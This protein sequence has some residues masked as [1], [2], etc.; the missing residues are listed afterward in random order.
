[1]DYIPMSWLEYNLVL[2]TILVKCMFL[3]YNFTLLQIRRDHIAD[4]TK[5]SYFLKLKRVKNIPDIFMSL[6]YICNSNDITG[7]HMGLISK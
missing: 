2:L 7:A 1:M 5:I 6:L 3:L 4:I